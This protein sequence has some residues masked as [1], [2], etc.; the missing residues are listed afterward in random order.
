MTR[1]LFVILFIDLNHFFLSDY[2]SEA[3]TYAS[4]E[5]THASEATT[6]ASEATTHASEATTYASEATT[7]ASEAI[8][9]A[10]EESGWPPWMDTQNNNLFLSALLNY[11]RTKI[12]RVGWACAKTVIVVWAEKHLYMAKVIDN[13]TTQNPPHKRR[14]P[15]HITKLKEPS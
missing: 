1:P 12:G 9:H 11:F 15:K 14:Y 8:T 2:A 13:N 10:S 7:H 6:H 4:E 3:T 5:T